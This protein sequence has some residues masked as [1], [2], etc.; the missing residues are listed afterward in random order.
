M[1]NL[2]TSVCLVFFLMLSLSIAQ[3]DKLTQLETKVNQLEKTLSEQKDIINSLMAKLLALD[4]KIDKLSTGTVESESNTIIESPAK[5]E[6]KE[7][8]SAGIN[9]DGT[10]RCQATT[11]K[12]TQCKRNAQIGSKYCWQHQR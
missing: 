7:K 9:E 12:G 11:Q 8:K 6:V 4:N 3:E 1:K 5:K 10:M 2:I